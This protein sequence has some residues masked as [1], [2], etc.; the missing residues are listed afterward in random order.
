MQRFR[1]R[2][3]SGSYCL[4]YRLIDS[5]CEPH[6]QLDGQYSSLDEA[7]A[8]AIAWVEPLEDPNPAAHMIG[9][10]VSTADGNWRTCRLPGPLLCS[11]LCVLPG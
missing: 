10:D 3:A 7:L 6:R 2:Q 5:G 11:L 9:V 4:S 1:S 8:D